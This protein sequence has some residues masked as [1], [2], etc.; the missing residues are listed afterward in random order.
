MRDDDHVFLRLPASEVVNAFHQLYYQSLA[1]DRN[2][3]LGY[4]I[5]QC[6]FDLHVLPGAPDPPPAAVHHPDRS[7]RWW[8]GLVFRNPARPDPF[9]PGCDRH[10]RRHPPGR[11]RRGPSDILGFDSSR[12][13]RPKTSVRSAPS[14]LCYHVVGDG[15]ARLGPF[16]A[17]C[18]EGN[19][20]LLRVRGD[21]FVSRC[22]KIQT[23]IVTRSFPGSVQG[24]SRRWK[25][26]SP[27]MAD[28]S[29]RQPVAGQSLLVPSAWLA[30]T[31]EVIGGRRSTLWV[32]ALFLAK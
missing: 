20:K 22:V 27:M 32:S 4:Q 2:T 31:G 24:L 14:N 6:P 15:R 21:R 13:A 3:F 11:T 30:E 23:S 26:F 10:R 25:T 8:V 9:R 1:W 5:K 16:P 19:Q 28:S 7:R 18:D 29:K 17:A 12:A